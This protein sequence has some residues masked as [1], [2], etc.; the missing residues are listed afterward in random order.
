MEAKR[1][2]N[3]DSNLTKKYEE[4]KNTAGNFSVVEGFSDRLHTIIDYAEEINIPSRE[5]R[6]RQAAIAKITNSSKTAAGGWLKHNRLPN[7]ETLA[8]C[9]R[10]FRQYS[11]VKPE[12]KIIESYLRFGEEVTRNP[13]EQSAHKAVEGESSDLRLK[14]FTILMEAV[15]NRHEGLVNYN[16]DSV[17]EDAMD[18]IEKLGIKIDNDIKSG[19][20][21]L[22]AMF[23]AINI[24]Q[25]IR[26]EDKGTQKI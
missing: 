18:M 7:D 2:I 19:T 21:E 20:K 4:E 17:L 22:I 1:L 14:A 6:G 5:Q 3:I 15:R 23:I 24:M 8:T 9:A 16:I 26:D 12:S 13:Y 11:K 25:A 10:F